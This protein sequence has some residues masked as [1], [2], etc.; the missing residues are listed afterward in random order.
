MFVAPPP[1]S[2]DVF[3]G[4]NPAA[5]AMKPGAI[6]QTRL[7]SLQLLARNN[8]VVN[9]DNH[10]S[11]LSVWIGLEPIRPATRFVKPQFRSA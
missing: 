2:L 1:R 7:E 3:L 11:I 9:I 8:M 4:H 6:N 5:G 10:V